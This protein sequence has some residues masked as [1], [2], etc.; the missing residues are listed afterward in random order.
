P[1]AVA[2]F[3]SHRREVIRRLMGGMRAARFGVVLMRVVFLPTRSFWK[4][5]GCLFRAVFWC[6]LGGL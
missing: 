5:L 3:C 1:G 4:H 6:A 2:F